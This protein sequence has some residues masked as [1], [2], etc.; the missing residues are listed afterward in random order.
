MDI[1]KLVE[2]SDWFRWE[3]DVMSVIIIHGFEDLLER[4]TRPTI[5]DDETQIAFDA[6]LELWENRQKQIVTVVSSSLSYF[7]RDHIKGMTTLSEVMDALNRWFQSYKTLAFSVLYHEY[8]SLTLQD[9]AN[10]TEYAG[11][12]S[13][14]RA[15]LGEL[16]ESCRI[17][18]PFLI[19]KFVTGLGGNYETIPI[20]FNQKHE[21][22]PERE[23]GK[24]IKRA[25]TFRE[26][27]DAAR[28]QEAIQKPQRANIGVTS[29]RSR[30]A[31]QHCHK[32]GHKKERCWFLHPELRAKAV[33]RRQRKI[34]TR[35]Q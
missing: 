15:N 28:L 19:N 31:C 12:L 22:L 21:L 8:E 20:I 5:G 25:I 4:D 3:Q 35:R 10:V 29:M 27:V 32:S 17:G 34:Q 6:R 1:A 23:D 30:E 33:K 13:E 11:K 2:W 14:V 26:A 7:N 18:E 24:I 9:C 16:D